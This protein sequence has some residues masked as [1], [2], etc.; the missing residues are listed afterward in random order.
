LQAIDR[1]KLERTLILVTHRVAAA[2]RCETI[3]VLDDGKITEQGT[4]D[5]LLGNGGLYAKFAEEQEAQRALEVI[6][7][8]LSA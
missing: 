4:H 6:N 1:Q 7:E 3:I 8:E 2:A 5:A